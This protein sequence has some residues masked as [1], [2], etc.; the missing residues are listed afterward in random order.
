MAILLVGAGLAAG[1][2]RALRT[3]DAGQVGR[4]LVGAL[5]QVPAAWV[6]DGVAVALFGVVGGDLA[7]Y[8]W[9]D[10]PA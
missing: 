7:G 10:G 4:V 9:Y 6:L 1:V 8:G 5:V 2:V 3:G